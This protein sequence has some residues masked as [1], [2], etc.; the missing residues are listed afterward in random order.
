MAKE[1]TSIMLTKSVKDAAK[2]AAENDDRTL[3]S[4]I[5]IALRKLLKVDVKKA[6]KNN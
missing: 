6:K 4:W 1:R 3:S 5:D 2:K